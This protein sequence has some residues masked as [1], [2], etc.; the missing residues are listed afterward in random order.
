MLLHDKEPKLP[1][2]SDLPRSSARVWLQSRESVWNLKHVMGSL[3]SW[4]SLTWAQSRLKAFLTHYRSSL[5][6]TYYTAAYHVCACARTHGPAHMPMRRRVCVVCMRCVCCACM[7]VRACVEGA[8]T[9]FP[10]LH[11]AGGRGAAIPP[12]PRPQLRLARGELEAN[13]GGERLHHL[14]Q[15]LCASN[16]GRLS[17]F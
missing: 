13:G 3:R 11:F 9:S 7:C 10:S 8:P 14:E 6:G 15:T 2:K 12:C 16:N 1:D 4:P 5:T 17:N